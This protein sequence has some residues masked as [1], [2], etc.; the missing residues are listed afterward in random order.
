MTLRLILVA[1]V[2]TQSSEAVERANL[3]DFTVLAF[4]PSKHAPMGGMLFAK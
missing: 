2:L 4:R 3:R 1:S